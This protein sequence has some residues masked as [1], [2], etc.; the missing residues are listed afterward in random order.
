MKHAFQKTLKTL[1][2]VMIC[3]L[4]SLSSSM[5]TPISVKADPPTAE[6]PAHEKKLIDNG[7]GTYT[8]ALSVTGATQSS[9]ITQIGR[10]HV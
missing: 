5:M 3:V 8:L 9:T 2:A 7:D 1:L 10:A 4:M 6:A